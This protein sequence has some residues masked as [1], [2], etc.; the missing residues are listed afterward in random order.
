MV[1]LAAAAAGLFGQQRI[2]RQGAPAT[3]A[4]QGV[5][6]NPLGLGLGGVRVRLL[7]LSGGAGRETTSTGDGV[8]R[9]TGLRPGR[10]RLNS[11]RFCA[12]GKPTTA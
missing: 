1:I 9:M 5:F 10:Y 2:P 3:A 11:Q 6:R 4:V 12:E 8:F 7:G